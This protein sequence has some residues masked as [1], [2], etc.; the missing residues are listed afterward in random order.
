MTFDEK[1]SLVTGSDG[2]RFADSICDF[3]LLL[4][5]YSEPDLCFIPNALPGKSSVCGLYIDGVV[6]VIA[7]EVFD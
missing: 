7:V 2:D 6:A 5:L 1:P 3:C 4:L